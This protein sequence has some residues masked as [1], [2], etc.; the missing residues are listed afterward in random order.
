MTYIVYV[1]FVGLVVLFATENLHVV[2]FYFL[3]SFEA[4][5]VLI[6]GIAFFVGF[7][8]AVLGVLLQ[9]VRQRKKKTNVIIRPRR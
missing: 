5:L 3:I 6:V 7:A 8:A 9:A 2:P 4:P 1:I